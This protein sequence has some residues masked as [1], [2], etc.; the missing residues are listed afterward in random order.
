MSKSP[1]IIATVIKSDFPAPSPCCL[2]IND[3]EC[4]F[5]N[6]KEENMVR[7]VNQRTANVSTKQNVNKFPG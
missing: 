2:N 1:N 3:V 5:E 6:I 4:I 7:Q